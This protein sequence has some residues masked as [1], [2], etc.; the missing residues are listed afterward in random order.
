M[1]SS[2]S[3]P[4]SSPSPSHRHSISTSKS[5]KI[6]WEMIFNCAWTFPI[7][8]PTTNEID[9]MISCLASLRYIYTCVICREHFKALWASDKPLLRLTPTRAQKG[10]QEVLKCIIDIYN[11]IQTK[12]KRPLTNLNYINE[13]FRLIASPEIKS[14]YIGYVYQNDIM[15]KEYSSNYTRDVCLPLVPTDLS[16]VSDLRHDMTCN[17]RN[18][19]WTNPQTTYKSMALPMGIFAAVIIVVVL[20]ILARRQRSQRKRD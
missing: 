14:S 18:A 13:R 9:A 17:S 7:D 4:S 1:S 11:S 15:R 5:G 20:V 12:L 6:V 16:K 10:Q 19:H 3:T 8:N 2:S